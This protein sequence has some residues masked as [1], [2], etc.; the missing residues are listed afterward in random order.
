MASLKV[1]IIVSDDAGHTNGAL[2]REFPAVRFISGPRRGPAANRNAGARAAA[3]EWLLFCDDD[4]LPEPNL[5]EVYFQRTRTSGCDVIEGAILADRPRRHP[6]EESPINDVGGNLWSC[7]FAIRRRVFWTVGG[8]DERFPAPAGED[9]ELCY[10]LKKAG[11]LIHYAPDAVVIHPWRKRTAAG[12]L[13]QQRRCLESELIA[14]SIH[15]ELRR[16]STCYA[17]AKDV[18][19]YYLRTFIPQLRQMGIAVV[20]TQPLLWFVQLRRFAAFARLRAFY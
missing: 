20:L 7:N 13:H 9:A 14:I 6:F 5:L 4:C 17:V 2:V 19:R 11:I 1:E 15:P 16:V 12:F 18:V 3:G 10:R 8:F